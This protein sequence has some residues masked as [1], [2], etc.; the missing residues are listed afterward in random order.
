[1]VLIKQFLLI[2]FIFAASSAEEL[3]E[4]DPFID[5]PFKPIKS[6]ADRIREHGYPAESHFIETTDG[7]VLN[8]FRIPYSPKLNN[9]D[10]GNPVV[11]LQHGLF[12]C[13]DSFILNGPND[14]IA[15][16]FA[17][18]GFDVWLG[19]ARG[20]IYSRNNTRLSLNHPNFWSFSWH[21]IGNID[22]PE[23]IDYILNKTG[24][25]KVHYV[26]HSQG[27]TVFF[28]MASTRP[29]YNKKIKTAHMLAPPIFM[30]NVTDNLVVGLAPYVGTPGKGSNF[31]GNQQFIPY[32]PF[33]QRLLDTA[34]GGKSAFP[35]YCSTLFFLWAGSENRNLNM[36]LLPLLAETHPAG[37][38]T[39][40]G[41][42]YIQEY[43]S[44]EFRQFDHGE[45]KNK[46]KYGQTE[47][48]SYPIE[49]ITSNMYIYYG[50]AD[51]SAN[52][53]DIQRLRYRLPNIKLFYEVPDSHWGHLDFIFARQ[54]KKTINDPVIQICV[55]YE[56]KN[57][58]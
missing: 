48:P 15:F 58:L 10:R 9:K 42:H 50:L 11:F 57:S 44:N 22:I 14:S 49:L 35:K 12:S 7:Y 23:M 32:N 4:F 34:C 51:T 8:M 37:I 40:Q 54:V 20:N 56:H 39:N 33:V 27:N 28:V 6:S 53:K 26:G 36:T 29:E 45:R 13:S 24:E 55:E 2:L 3:T 30:G 31:L 5:I 52:Y 43:V 47:P 21:E 1:M 19:N 16:N 18:N 41:I 46:Q 17:D 38:S 25:T